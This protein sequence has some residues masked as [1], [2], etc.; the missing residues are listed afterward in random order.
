VAMGPTGSS[1]GS[2]CK[3]AIDATA[4][5]YAVAVLAALTERHRTHI[6]GEPR[7]AA[8]RQ[9]PRGLAGERS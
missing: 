4:L 7:H 9:A 6:G 3:V 8:R 1:P 5:D 2:D